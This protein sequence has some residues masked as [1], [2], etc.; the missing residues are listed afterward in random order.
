MKLVW[1]DSTNNVLE[2]FK[3]YEEGKLPVNFVRVLSRIVSEICLNGEGH[4]WCSSYR[5]RGLKKKSD[6]VLRW[7]VTIENQERNLRKIWGRFAHSTERG[8]GS[9]A[10]FWSFNQL[11]RVDIALSTLVME[12]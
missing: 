4:V 10:G 9:W 12:V 11:L 7:D 5:A 1:R 3:Q 8:M 2:N 6:F